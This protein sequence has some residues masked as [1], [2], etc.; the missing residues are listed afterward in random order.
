MTAIPAR[1]R[2]DLSGKELAYEFMMMLDR[3]CPGDEMVIDYKAFIA[4][5]PDNEVTP[6]AYP[7]RRWR[8][9][10]T[11][12]LHIRRFHNDLEERRFV[13]P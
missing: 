11:R 12:A 1:Y 3:L 10:A 6:P 8:N 13:P 7:H 2:K 9:E 5:G 4:L